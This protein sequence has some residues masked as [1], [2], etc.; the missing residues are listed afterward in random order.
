MTFEFIDTLVG[1]GVA[2]VAYLVGRR[3]KK[4]YKAQPIAPMCGCRHHRSY[5]KDDGPCGAQEERYDSS[6]GTHY[7]PCGCQNY[8]GPKPYSQVM[9]E[10]E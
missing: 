9:D 1:A 3:S 4:P 6:R 5:H 2:G 7:G 10:I 8:V